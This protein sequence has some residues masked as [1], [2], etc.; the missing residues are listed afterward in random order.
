VLES[1]LRVHLE[2]F[3]S[4]NGLQQF[5]GGQSNP[6]FLLE[7]SKKNFVL[8]KKPPGELLESAHQIER[9][10][11]IMKAL[12]DSEVP[13][14]KM[15]LLCTDTAVVGTSFYVMDWIEGRIFRDPKLP[16]VAREERSAI[17]RALSETLARLHM[18]DWQ[19][20][21]LDYFGK[22]ENFLRRQ[23]KRWSSQY[24]AAKPKDHSSS[25]EITSDPSMDL[26]SQWLYENIP[27]EDASGENAS[28]V[29]GDYRLENLIFHPSKPEVLAVID[30]ELS[31]LGDRLSDL[32]YCC[33]PYHLPSSIDELPGLQGIDFTATGI[34][35]EEHF[36]QH[37]FDSCRV[38]LPG[39]SGLGSSALSST[40]S[41]G[42]SN[43]S[44]YVAFSL[45]RLA[46]IAQGIR[47]RAAQGIASSAKA[48]RVGKLADLFA[49]TGWQIANA[50]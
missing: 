26:L 19:K 14:P 22:R 7:T 38:A 6:T 49:R 1:Y 29:H 32:G 16:S 25:S 34:P 42:M 40:V 45:F 41:G 47:K 46:A 9:E 23:I 44:Y 24:E 10:Y 21:G 12:Q 3:D 39:Q 28:I 18:V 13:V 20:L 43:N 8:R 48:E 15:H 30:W 31:T 11:Q 4:L 37:Y 5:K 36:L 27:P 17:Y 33:I 50:Q 35:S 2:D